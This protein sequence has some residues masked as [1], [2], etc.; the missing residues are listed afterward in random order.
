MPKGTVLIDEERCQ[1]CGLCVASC[2]WALLVLAE[3]RLNGHGRHPVM[4]VDPDSI[5]S[6]CGL[7]AVVCPNLALMAYRWR[8]EP[9]LAALTA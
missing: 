1:G 5:C 9:A 8:A 2:P 6:G 7:C 3:D 4:L